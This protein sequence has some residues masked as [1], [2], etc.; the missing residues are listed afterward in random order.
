MIH[1]WESQIAMFVSQ[2]GDHY[3]EEL[4][5]A[6]F[7]LILDAWVG[8][9]HR[10]I[11]VLNNVETGKEGRVQLVGAAVIDVAGTKVAGKSEREAVLDFGWAF[12]RNV[13]CYTQFVGTIT[14]KGKA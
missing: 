9:G 7:S 5:L 8:I 14:E 12:A 4:V 11:I 3:L 10:Q 2:I 6:W 1:I 13:A